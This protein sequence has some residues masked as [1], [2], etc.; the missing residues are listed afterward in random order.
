MKEP[1][2]FLE[3]ILSGLSLIG[4]L[5]GY[6][7]LAW[8]LLGINLIVLLLFSRGF[9]LEKLKELTFER[10]MYYILKRY[11]YK[12]NDIFIQSTV[13]ALLLWLTLKYESQNI[14]YPIEIIN[15][16]FI[17]SIPLICLIF[18][19]DF[20]ISK[21][22]FNKTTIFCIAGYVLVVLKVWG[23]LLNYTLGN[24]IY[25]IEKLF[26]IL[27][28]AVFIKYFSLIILKIIKLLIE[29][30]QLYNKFNIAK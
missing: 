22:T 9:Y 5:L 13:I 27:I 6:N 7:N 2:V 17:I 24:S 30:K 18:A 21:V 20:F 28:I 3:S 26:Y 29:Q 4:F 10:D 8:L 25:N 15:Y 1:V 12:V 14:L 19:Y 11:I 16:V 23:K